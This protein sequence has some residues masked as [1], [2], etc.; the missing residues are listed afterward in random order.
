[1][2]LTALLL[3]AA[4]STLP[5]GK[6]KDVVQQHCVGCHALK[7]VTSKRATKE[8]WAS[9]VDQMVSR[10]AEVD[11]DDIEGVVEY[12]AANFGPLKSHSAGTQ[13][14]S[15]KPVNVNTATAAQLAAALGI[16]A[17]EAAAI[18]SYREE[19]GS[20]KEWAELTQVPGI[21]LKQIEIHRNR[22]TF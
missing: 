11:D 4:S 13:G 8:Q 15:H 17:K 18:V 12:L 9:L 16:P 6:G 2:L 21:D 7:V 3:F 19:N 14:Q 1:M 10:G 22:L 20:F 5:A